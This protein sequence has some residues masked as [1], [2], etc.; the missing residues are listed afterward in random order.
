M[1]HRVGRL[2]SRAD[3][4]PSALAPGSLDPE[5][6]QARV[7][8]PADAGRALA[9]SQ[10]HRIGFEADPLREGEVIEQPQAAPKLGTTG[11][12]LAR[13]A[14][15]RRRQ[16]RV[17][18]R[19]EILHGST[20]YATESA[21]HP[22]SDGFASRK[23]EGTS[24]LRNSGRQRCPSGQGSRRASA[25]DAGDNFAL[26]YACRSVLVR[27]SKT[28]TPALGLWGAPISKSRAL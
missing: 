4:S 20:P 8:L 1:P 26:F 18:A 27:P 14:R 12:E 17:K 13:P 3:R 21:S 23:G 10:D 16:R 25:L 24:L 6:D 5:V 2:P 15:S 19:G 22:Q 11:F 7:R 9:E 28:D